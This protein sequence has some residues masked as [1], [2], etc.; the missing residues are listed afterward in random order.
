MRVTYIIR[1]IHGYKAT[2]TPR[3]VNLLKAWFNG[4]IL[5][6]YLDR[7]NVVAIEKDMIAEIDGA[8]G[9]YKSRH[10]L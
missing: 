4:G 10:T 9:P 3:T 5:Y 6:G 7:Y 8:P 2:D 1:D